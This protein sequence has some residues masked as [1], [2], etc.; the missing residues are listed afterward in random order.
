LCGIGAWALG[1]I[2]ILSFNTWAFPFRIFGIVK[3][4]G[5]FDVMQVVTAQLL[6]P[7]SGIL[8][9]LFAGWVMKPEMTREALHMRSAWLHTVWLW[10]MRVV[11]P[12]LLLIV[13]FNL[14]DLFA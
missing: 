2:T 1:V 12:V 4:L 5:F 6:L 8:I 14:P 11:V 10:L 13:I 3:K 9:A 7:V